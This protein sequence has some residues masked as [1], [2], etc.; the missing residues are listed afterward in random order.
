M[1]KRIQLTLFVDTNLSKEIEAIRQ[2]YNPAQYQLIK[3]HVTLCRENELTSL[4]MVIRNL[5]QLNYPIITIQFEP[6]KTFS[7]DEGVL[8]PASKNNHTFDELRKIVLLGTTNVNH[9]QEPH[10]TLMHP[11]NSKCTE[12]IFN[13]IKKATLPKSIEFNTISL[14]EQE[15]G[16][17]WK[18]LKEYPLKKNI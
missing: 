15:N 17:A 10:I 9:E 18:V 4:D 14:I 16:G 13:E 2:S 7:N 12:Q 11:R 1:S 5:E 6:V 8:L 3:S